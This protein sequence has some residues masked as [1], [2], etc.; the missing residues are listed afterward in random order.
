VIG[1]DLVVRDGE[2]V[3]DAGE[4]D[5]YDSTVRGYKK[6]LR[7]DPEAARAAARRVI[8]NTYR[9]LMSRGMRGCYVWS[10]DEE[11]NEWLKA[12]AR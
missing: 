1:P 7:E 10:V 9:T 11:T 2:V 6:W 5:R 8:L 4:R 3:T 12:A